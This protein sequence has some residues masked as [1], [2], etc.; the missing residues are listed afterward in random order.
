MLSDVAKG[1]AG[2]PMKTE[3]ETELD[4]LFDAATRQRSSRD[5]WCELH[6]H[7]CVQ[8]EINRIAARTFGAMTMVTAAERRALGVCK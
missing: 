3:L 7:H 2:C 6:G 8:L 4:Q 1:W 5:G